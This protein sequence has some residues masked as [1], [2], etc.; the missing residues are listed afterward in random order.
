MGDSH[1]RHQ[2]SQGT[3]RLPWGRT[4]LG[5]WGER[6][7]VCGL[8][9]GCRGQPHRTPGV[10][11]TVARDGKSGLSSRHAPDTGRCEGGEREG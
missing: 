10:S 11:E 7:G 1:L 8:S 2:A 9:R 6:G 4:E 3:C 5:S